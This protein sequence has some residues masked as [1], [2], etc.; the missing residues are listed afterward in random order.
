MF[1]IAIQTV[2][3][4]AHNRTS[5]ELLNGVRQHVSTIP[6]VESHYCRAQTKRLY[7][8]AGLTIPKLYALYVEKSQDEGVAYVSERL[9]RNTFCS[10]FNISA[11]KPRKDQCEIC[12]TFDSLKGMLGIKL[13]EYYFG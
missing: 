3:R 11:F 10:E 12:A 1:P 4:K 5:D 2:V 6:T 13:T 7:M 9:Y 8:E